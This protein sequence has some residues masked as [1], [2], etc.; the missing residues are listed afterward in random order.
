MMTRTGFRHEI[1]QLTISPLYQ[2]TNTKIDM[3]LLT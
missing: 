1:T 3:K 2:N